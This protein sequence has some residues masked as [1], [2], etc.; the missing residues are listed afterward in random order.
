MSL[1][2]AAGI[3]WASSGIAVQDF[4]AHSDKSAIDLTNIRMLFSGF[5]ILIIAWQN[6][7]LKKS[8]SVL[9]HRPRMWLD[10]V[11][12]GTVGMAFMQFSYFEAISIGGAVATTVIQYSCPAIVVLWHSFYYRRLPKLGEVIAVIL[13]T[14]GVF[15]LV[16]GGNFDK[17]M[18]PLA[19][20]LWALA[21][22][23][24][25][26]FSSIF[27][28]HLF[29]SGID[30]YF[31]TSV[32]M[33]IGGFF[34]F[35]LVDEVNLADFFA[36]NVI[37]DVICIIIFGTVAAFLLFNAGLIY[38][39]A[40]EASVTATTEPVASVILAYFIFGTTFGLIESIGIVLVILAI[41]APIILNHKLNRNKH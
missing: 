28:S 34:T 12:Y 41:L 33:I 30:K 7:G 21:S 5:L 2:G 27:P 10:V 19:C 25:F 31:L 32:G 16:T 26:A 39:T 40:E 22:G 36:S 15:L 8:F 38:L 20:V 35:A 23:A 13:A 9:N 14:S 3:F 24:S 1:V 29:T 18:V 4:F 17:L 6:G 11:I 37:F